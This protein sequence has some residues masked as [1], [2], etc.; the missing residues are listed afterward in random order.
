MHT[1]AYLCFSQL[2]ADGRAHYVF[3][4]G[5][6]LITLPSARVYILYYLQID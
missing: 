1:L 2:L 4:L 3:L 5:G 6:S